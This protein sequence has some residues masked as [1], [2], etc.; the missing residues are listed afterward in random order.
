MSETSKIF[1]S[2]A[3]RLF[4]GEQCASWEVARNNFEALGK[5]Q[6]R[7]LNIGENETVRLQYNPARIVSTTAKIDEYSLQ[8]RPCF[9][10]PSNRPPQQA[11]IPFGND[12]EILVNPYPILPF[13]LTIPTANHTPQR[14]ARR[15]GTL[16]Q[17]SHCLNEFIVFYNGPRCGASAPD[18]AHFQAGAKGYLP[19]ETEDRFTKKKT[20]APLICS[21]QSAGLRAYP[22]CSRPFFEIRSAEEI[23]S[24]YLFSL[25]L[26]VLQQNAPPGAGQDEEPMMNLLAWNQKGESILRIFPRRQHRPS[27]YSAPEGGRILISPGALDMGGLMAVSRKS[28]FES[29]TSRS[30]EAI[31]AEVCISPEQ[32]E[33]L[34]R[35]L[36]S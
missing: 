16:F 9:L 15:M 20:L 30:L 28:D 13:H 22:F 21:Y 23:E 6:T 14:I 1:D 7:E 24:I 34:A 33:E 3:A 25:V 19:M 35:Q 12:Y 18:H 36:K 29:L 27:C 5:I 32:M 31:F 4:V 17:L 26:Q 10:C 8:N 11:A 2:K